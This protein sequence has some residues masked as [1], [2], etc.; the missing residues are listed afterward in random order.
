[1]KKIPSGHTVR[2]IK[3]VYILAN[4]CHESYVD[5]ALLESYF[6]N[7]QIFS[8]VDSLEEADL[9]LFL[10]C[11]SMQIKEEETQETIEVLNKKKRPDAKLLIAGCVS[12]VRPEWVTPYD[13]YADLI[14][15]ING[16]LRLNEKAQEISAH[17]PY[18]PYRGSQGTVLDNVRSQIRQRRVEDYAP[19]S[20]K[21]PFGSLKYLSRITSFILSKY[22]DFIESRVDVW[23]EKTYAVKISTGCCGNCSYC[24]IKQSRGDICSKP[25][26]AVINEIKTG[27]NN[28]YRDFALI[29]TDIGDYGT[30]I[31]TNLLELLKSIVALPNPLQLRLRNV[32]PRWLI[33]NCDP[34][35]DLIKS[36][37]ITYIQSPIQ[38]G[39]DRI[40]KRMNRQYRA[41]D[42]LIA[43]RKIRKNC[44]SVFLKTQIIVGF[45]GE[46]KEDFTA[47]LKLYDSALFNYIDVFP[48][49][50]RPNTKASTLSDQIAQEIIMKRR[51]K[52]LLK[53]LFRLGPIQL[54][55]KG[56]KMG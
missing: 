16:L 24:S 7:N 25:I 40:L 54:F 55:S 2:L 49:H 31:G 12:K 36:S 50:P 27:L 22:K 15:D 29:G 3:R 26:E 47:S 44:S 17:F 43:I 23:T 20:G 11:T 8:Q 39:S 5:A 42:Y 28:G 18:R 38:T 30:D 52:L 33:P 46:T 37:K 4:G 35:I 45:P 51:R 10:G 9:I 56:L 53:S 19:L 6:Q 34:L 41:E 21:I 1:M 13:Q 32:N 14:R 48:Y